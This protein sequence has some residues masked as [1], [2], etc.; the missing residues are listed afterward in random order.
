MQVATLLIAD[1]A[2]FV[3]RRVETL[4]L[5]LTGIAGDRHAGPMRAADA[6]TPW[7]KR[8]TA[9]ANTR[10]IS[11]LSVEECAE[12]ARAMDIPVVQPELLG[13]NLVLSEA[14]GL[15]LLPSATRL[16][17]PSGAT[18]F[19]TEQNAPC[20]FPAEKLAAAH[21][22]PRLAALF[23]KAA[24]GRRGLVG[25]VECEGEVRTG[26]AVTYLPPRGQVT[27]RAALR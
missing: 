5:T 25:I 22:R 4:C 2:D 9:I 15:S 1:G 18:I 12:V 23:P 26:D 21:G 13:A 17:F 14:P 10:Q 20:R 16:R 27:Q 6:R 3:S 24:I 7:H 11:L 8:G 19:V